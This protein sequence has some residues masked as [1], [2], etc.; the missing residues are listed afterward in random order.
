M[1]TINCTPDPAAL[2]RWLRHVYQTDRLLAV[3]VLCAGW[4]MVTR[5]RAARVCDGSM[6]LADAINAAAGTA[7][8]H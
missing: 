8:A 1:E 3:K 5:Y 6:E 2:V 4:P 7:T